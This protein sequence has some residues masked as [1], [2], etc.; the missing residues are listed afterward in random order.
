MEPL[1]L[2]G[3]EGVGEGDVEGGGAIGGVNTEGHGLANLELCAEKVDLVVGLDLL[4]VLG[5]G[6][7]EGK[8]TL[9]LEV[10][11]VDTSEGAGDDGKTTKVTGL[12]SG[13]LTGRALTVVPVTDNDPADALALVV[14]GS[15]RDS[16]V[17]AGGE[18]VDLVGL[19]VLGVDGTNQHVVGNVV[20]VTAV[21]EPGA[22]HTKL[23]SV[24]RLE[25]QCVFLN[26]IPDV[27][28]GGLA[29]GLDENGQIKSIALVPCVE[30]LKELETVGG[31]ADG[32]VDGA[33]VLGRGLVGVH[34]GVVS[35]RGKTSAGGLLEHELVAVLVLEGVGERVEV[36]GAGQRHGDNEIGGGDE[37]VGGRVC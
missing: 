24:K 28:G 36:Q 26:L 29:L 1:D 14:T 5:I 19:T 12:E 9:L 33:A 31:G 25:M 21:L 37:G 3:V 30:R 20:E 34:A 2:A 16:V 10:G 15:G 32:N 13:V 6:E 35:T 17:L 11:L 8:H 4:V 27:I 23:K 22:G 7:G 18:V